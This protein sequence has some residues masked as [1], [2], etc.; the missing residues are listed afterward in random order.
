MEFFK[1]K[2]G[3]N[4]G[5][6]EIDQQHRKFLE[7]LN[8]C[9]RYVQSEGET[10]VDAAMILKLKGYAKAHFKF[11]EDLMTA[12]DYQKKDQHIRQHEY[13][14]SQIA[15]LEDKGAAHPDKAAEGLLAFLRDWFLSHILER[16]REFAASME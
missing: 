16:D 15:K 8:E 3:F 13:F 12:Y 7:Y 9:H 5:I 10:E 1:W 4:I 14:V 11:E 2:D 6:E